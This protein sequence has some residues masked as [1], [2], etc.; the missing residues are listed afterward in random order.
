MNWTNKTQINRIHGL[1]DVRR[2][3]RLGKIRLG[4]KVK[5]QKPDSRCKHKPAEICMYCSYPREVP[6][7]VCPPNVQMVY[8]P[9]P[10]AIDV[11]I[12]IEDERVSFPQALKWYVASRLKCKGDGVQAT[13]RVMDLT[14]EQKKDLNG[15]L[16]TDPNDMIDV[17]CPCPLLESGECKQAG[18]L[19][20]LLPK[21][22]MGGVFQID[23]GSTNN[24]IRINSAIDYVRALVGRVALVPLTLKRVPE[25]IEFEGKRRTHYLLALEFGGDIN[26]VNRLRDN[27]KMILEDVKRVALPPPVEDGPEPTGDVVVQEEIGNGEKPKEAESILKDGAPQPEPEPEFDMSQV[28]NEKELKYFHTLIT[29]SGLPREMV[30]DY[31]KEKTGKDSSKDLTR[32]EADMILRWV[33]SG[34]ADAGKTVK[35]K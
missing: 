26:V 22:S 32:E 10:T 4:V 23:T 3:P 9:E 33:T 27:T 35:P 17:T 30:K 28:I 13:R 7:F 6:Y 14:E 1:S 31:M 29:K 12:P 25:D 21:V 2:L 18:N 34:T 24:I 5:K 16:P 19:M 11:M 8:G 15:D 20:V